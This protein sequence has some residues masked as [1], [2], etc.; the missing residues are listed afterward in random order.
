MWKSNK[1]SN[2]IIF[3][4]LEILLLSLEVLRNNVEQFIISNL[5]CHLKKRRKFRIAYVR[6]IY[7]I[8]IYK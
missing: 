6:F 4:T 5:F 8:E 3:V 2:I 1:I 7:F